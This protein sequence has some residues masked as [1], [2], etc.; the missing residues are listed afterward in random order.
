MVGSC[1]SEA[2]ELGTVGA[3][4]PED[5]AALR[6]VEQ[7]FCADLYGE[8]EIEHGFEVLRLL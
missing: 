5:G 8:A 7:G 6:Q 1:A 2:T 4:E 3:Q